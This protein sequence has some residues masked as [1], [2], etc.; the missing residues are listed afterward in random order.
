MRWVELNKWIHRNDA[1]KKI[2]DPQK[3]NKNISKYSRNSTSCSRKSM[4]ND[5]QLKKDKIDIIKIANK[6]SSK[7]QTIEVIIRR[8]EE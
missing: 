3:E 4:T 6:V 2:K 8:D 7:Y 1:S 5:W